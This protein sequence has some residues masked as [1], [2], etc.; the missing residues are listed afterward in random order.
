[1]KHYIKTHPD[2][3]NEIRQVFGTLIATDETTYEGQYIHGLYGVPVALH[4]SV[5]VSYDADAN[6]GKFTQVVEYEVKFTDEE[7]EEETRD[8]E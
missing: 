5:D 8:T 2:N 1:M 7:H 6:G 3:L 4:V